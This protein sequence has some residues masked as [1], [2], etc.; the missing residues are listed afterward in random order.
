MIAIDASLDKQNE[1]LVNI[2]LHRSRKGLSMTIRAIPAIEDLMREW[3]TGE[4]QPVLA[5]GRNWIAPEGSVLEVW[6]L[7][8]AIG[9]LPYD[10]GVYSIERPG[11]LLIVEGVSLDGRSTSEV[12]NLSFLRLVGLSEGVTFKIAGVY[13]PD[14][15]EEVGTKIKKA[16]SRFWRT[17]MKDAT[18]DVQLIASMQRT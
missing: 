13:T 4:R 9:P 11:Q 15:L 5:H 17:Y 18:I 14:W 6:Q 12:I 2:T 16:T 10:G 1:H 3:G 8:Q 7:S